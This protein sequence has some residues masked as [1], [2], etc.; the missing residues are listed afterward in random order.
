MDATAMGA[1]AIAAA[2]RRREI[3]AA[4]TLERH[5]A[6]I[7]QRNPQLNAIV[8]ERF[9]D[10]RAEAAEADRLVA[11][12]RP[13]GPLH[14]VPV[15]IKEAVACQG[16]P[17]TS[18][19][20]L[21]AGQVAPDDA[22][23]VAALRR[24]GVIVLGV[25]NTPEFCCFYDTD[26]LLYGRTL[27]P[28][29]AERTPGGSSGGESAAIAAGMSPLG[30][31]SDLGSS[32]RNPA[33]W[34]GIFGIKPSAGLVPSLGHAFGV[35]PSFAR[36]GSIGPMAR[37]TA[38]LAA[39]LEAIA[40]RPAWPA[41]GGRF[42]VAV[43]EDDGLQPVAAAQRDAV[44][45]AARALA[46]AGHEP[47]DARPPHAA[48]AR[49]IFDTMLLTEGAVLLAPEIAARGGELSRYGAGFVQAISGV[50]PDLGAYLAAG[51]ELIELEHGVDTFLADYPIML[52]PVVPVTAPR[53]AEGITTVDGQPTRPGGKMTLSTY[54][55]VFG[56]PAAS[57]PAGRADDG[58]PLAVQVIGRRDHD[59]DVLRVAGEL[60]AA[61]GGWVS[62][63]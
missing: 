56:L 57:I 50:T 47:V 52:C 41:T 11:G 18:G 36:F 13:V 10:A 33:A 39:A 61:L 53:S 26:N 5:I 1:T 62:P 63:G 29:D 30:L 25:T 28:H 55:N 38:D 44:R 16:M 48:D 4:E 51:M 17:F 35:P 19:S 14:G 7:E 9:D 46:D 15:T 12:G 60:E 3:S 23:A 2:I 45:R 58:L 59:R 40:I 8:A 21:L 54:A 22:P 42:R 24:A 37:T 6:R 43:Y 20:K 27:N 32:I 49:R 31:G 34:T